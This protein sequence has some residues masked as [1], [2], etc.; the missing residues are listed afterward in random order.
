[1]NIQNALEIVKAVE[2]LGVSVKKISKDGISLADLPE[3]IELVKQ[4]DLFVAAF[5]D[6]GIAVEEI[7]DLDQ[8]ELLE[9]GSKVFAAFK[10]IQ[11][12]K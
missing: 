4:L 5:K 11:A 6:A 9:L 10:A 2:V 8:A 3:A 1:M 12:V 7:K